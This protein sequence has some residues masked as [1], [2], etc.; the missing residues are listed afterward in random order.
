MKKILIFLIAFLC[1][2][3]F[4]SVSAFSYTGID[5]AFAET[6]GSYALS[7][8]ILDGSVSDI[9]FDDVTQ[10]GDYTFLQALGLGILTGDWSALGLYGF[11]FLTGKVDSFLSS[12][13]NWIYTNLPDLYLWWSGGSPPGYF[14]VNPNFQSRGLGYNLFNTLSKGV[15]DSIVVQPDPDFSFVSHINEVYFSEDSS[16]SSKVD[17]YNSTCYEYNNPHPVIQG[18]NP[19]RATAYFVRSSP[20]YHTTGY[21]Q[22]GQLCAYQ[23]LTINVYTDSSDGSASVIYSTTQLSAFTPNG[24]SCFYYWAWGTHSLMQQLYS[25]SL[26]YA[27]SWQTS[28]DGLSTAINYIYS[29]FANIDLYVNGTPWVLRDSPSFPIDLNGLLTLLNSQP[30][31]YYYPPDIYI[32]L[33]GLTT[34]IKNAISNHLT[35]D[36]PYIDDFIVDVNGQKA[37]AVVNFQRS[38]YD[39]LISE[40]YPFDVRFY[41]DDEYLTDIENGVTI[42][43]NSS[44]VF[45]SRLFNTFLYCAVI[46]LFGLIIRRLIE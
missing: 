35:I 1:I 44:S 17:F 34:A 41:T 2:L 29:H 16:G 27:S 7:D 19:I 3:P 4:S 25:G 36:F 31:Q 39:N 33:T 8:M 46:L 24:N 6:V 14:E 21:W 20:T 26:N 42:L 38:D 9:S 15:S 28:F 23:P 12:I 43:N 37:V 5:L 13:D 10:Q 18:F 45:P 11:D 32:D 22:Y 30:A 40:Q